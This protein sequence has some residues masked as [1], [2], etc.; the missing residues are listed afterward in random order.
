MYMNAYPMPWDRKGKASR[1][2]GKEQGLLRG[3]GD[4]FYLRV[5]VG[6]NEG[7]WLRHEHWVEM[8]FSETYIQ[9]GTYPE[10]GSLFIWNSNLTWH[11]VFATSGNCARSGGR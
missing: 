7:I 4:C 6:G 11:P 1:S 3:A 9:Y 5:G 8:C 2:T 10:N